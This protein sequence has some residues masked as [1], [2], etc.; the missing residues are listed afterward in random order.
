MAFSLCYGQWLHNKRRNNFRESH[1]LFMKL[2]PLKKSPFSRKLFCQLVLRKFQ[3]WN[4]K[5]WTGK[6]AC[7]DIL[8][9][10]SCIRIKHLRGL[11]NLVLLFLLKNNGD[12]F[13]KFI[14]SS[15]KTLQYLLLVNR[16][17][18]WH[19]S[20]LA[21]EIKLM[22]ITHTNKTFMTAGVDQRH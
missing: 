13:T 22:F 2:H 1:D 9:I 5:H 3:C 21:D 12:K 17:Y 15:R 14:W 16:M 8:D 20:C 19:I 11:W 4:K 7:I 10:L 18:S 6:Q